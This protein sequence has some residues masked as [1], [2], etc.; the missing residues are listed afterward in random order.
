MA[1]IVKDAIMVFP[2]PTHQD[3]HQKEEEVERKFP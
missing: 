3:A 1:R 2:F